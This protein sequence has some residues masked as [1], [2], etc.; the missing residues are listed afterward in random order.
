MNGLR[1]GRPGLRGPD[2][3]HDLGGVSRV[4]RGDE[5]DVGRAGDQPVGHAGVAEGG[6]DR[7]TLRRP[8]GDRRALH[9]EP[10]AFEVDVVQLVPVDEAA[11]GDVADLRVVFPAVPE[12]AQHLDVVGR[13][14]EVTGDQLL[15]VRVREMIR[16]QRLDLPAAE[17]GGRAGPGGDLNPDP[18]PAAA[19]V[20]QGG[21]GLGQVERLGVGGDRG[22]H[23]PDMP[24]GGGDPGRDQHRVQ[25]APDPV[26]AG[27]S[28][29]A[30][31]GLKIQAV[32]DGEEV[33][34]AALGLLSQLG[35]VAG[36]EQPL[37]S[38][39]GFAPRGGMPASAVEGDGQVQEGRRRGH[40]SRISTSFPIGGLA[41]VIVPLENSTKVQ[42]VTTVH[43]SWSGE[44]H[45]LPAEK[46]SCEPSLG[47]FPEPKPGRL[48]ERSQ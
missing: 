26:G 1:A 48:P 41:V 28:R 31:V 45:H 47:L 37:R 11:G 4:A 39:V 35:P 22:R 10:A 6:D 17:V 8:R 5:A 29:Q 32:L 23:E 13:L 7:L 16:L 18:G 2:L 36:G 21:D 44:A 33:E 3:R 30:V 14:V 43:A 20:V 27:V 12:P 9:G 34:Q 42:T 46:S 19:H 24:G 25:T 38:R 15:D 40:S